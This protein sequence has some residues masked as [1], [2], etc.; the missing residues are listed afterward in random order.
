MDLDS[1]CEL[2]DLGLS[3]QFLIMFWI[4]KNTIYW[5]MNWGDKGS[6]N[7]NW[8]KVEFRNQK[9]PAKYWDFF[10]NWKNKQTNKHSFRN[11]NTFKIK[12][13]TTLTCPYK[14]KGHNYTLRHQNTAERLSSFNKLRPIVISYFYCSWMSTGLSQ[15]TAT[16]NSSTQLQACSQVYIIPLANNEE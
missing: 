9:I 2:K 15:H 6:C 16:S 14:T 12:E 8:M 11:K 1:S 7:E 10:H 4:S 13:L 3:S 5:I